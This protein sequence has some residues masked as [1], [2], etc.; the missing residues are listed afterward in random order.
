MRLE[1]FFHNIQQD[2]KT[3]LFF[4]LLICL[5]RAYFLW[6]MS[7]Y[8]EPETTGGDVALALWAGMRLSMKSAGAC[9]AGGFA[10]VTLLGIL[11]P[12]LIFQRLRLILGGI[13]CFL[14]AF[15][16]QAR[17][18]YFREF[19]ATFGMEVAQGMQDDIGAIFV[20]ALE[21][22]QLPA[23]LG[24]AVLLAVLSFLLLRWLLKARTLA[25]PHFAG[26]S[27][28]YAFSAGLAAF[29]AAAFI[30][31][32]FGASF[33]YEHSI[34]WQNAAVTNDAFLNECILDDFQGMYRAR[35][36]QKKMKS[37]MITGVDKARIRES[38][39][40]LHG[41]GEI[42]EDGTLKPWLMHTAQG[43]KIAKPRHIF[44][45]MGE[46][47]AAWP[48]M[49]KYADI[50]AADGIKSLAAQP[51][52]FLTMAFLP[53]GD[54]TSIALDGVITGLSDVAVR[55]NYQKRTYEEPYLTA[56]APQ[57]KALGYTV[58]YWY[59][60]LAS[61]DN[62]GKLSLAQGFDH[63]YG[64]PDYGA[65]QRS[66][67]GTT[68]QK[69]FDA[70][71]RHLAE[72]GPTV[73]LVMTTS[74]HPPYNLDLAEEGYDVAAAEQKVRELIPDAEDPAQLA[75][76]LGH[77]WY[78]DH[79]VTKFVR[80]TLEQYPDSL[81]V[82]TGDHAVRMD[83]GSHPTIYEHQAVPLLL[84]GA[85]ITPQILP[86]NVIGGHTAIVP[87]L[88][89]LIA[90]QGFTYY[91]IARSM[92]EGNQPAFHRDVWLTDH[93]IGEVESERAEGM[94][95]MDASATDFAAEKERVMPSLRAMRTV[96]WWLLQKGNQIEQGE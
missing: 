73:H 86:A 69:L 85:G 12:R 87:T 75:L 30:F 11:F 32:R 53:N 81:F 56:M 61:W 5:Y 27:A 33:N 31:I 48:M 14:L 49:E 58:D 13:F 24:A 3:F 7:G 45:I 63:F 6:Y 43:A 41:A 29:V 94:P 18:P 23:R 15:L 77:Y 37:G 67:W 82:L 47:W 92:T 10:F 50:H 96:S 55:P 21:E 90:P 9:T 25:L 34:N 22:Y 66:I 68:D 91:S 51:N 78:M 93:A 8:M 72:E 71:Y 44:I 38:L 2:G 95:G 70:L 20:T 80:Q 88:M 46:S 35:A 4:L 42:H 64:C 40:F 89:E 60:G 59:G 26:R 76:E 16:F 57:M 74:N 83:P 28:R 79:I 39:Q 52:S 54:F 17:F 19:Q 1:K 84:C 65:E 62:F 36:F